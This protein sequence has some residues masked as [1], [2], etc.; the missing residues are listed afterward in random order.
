MELKPTA[1]LLQINLARAIL[2]QEDGKRADEAIE[3]LQ[4]A[5][6]YEPDNAFAF[7]L[8]AQAYDAKGEGGLARLSAAE[9]RY[10]VGDLTQA[11]IFA[12]RA[13]EIL[14]KNTPQ[15]RRATDIVL[16]AKPTKDDL[17]QLGGS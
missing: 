12:L 15:W 8:M 5:L 1:P 3:H 6:A 13:R 10:A 9:E 2:A 14:P 16:V 11:R 7:Q 4:K 17:R